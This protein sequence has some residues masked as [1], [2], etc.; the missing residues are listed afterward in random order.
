MKYLINHSLI[1]SLVLLSVSCSDPQKKRPE[2]ENGFLD[3]SSWNFEEDGL[4]ELNGEWEFYWD[5]LLESKD[6]ELYDS[7]K[8]EY[9]HVPGGWATKSSGEKL[10][11]EFG[12]ATYR[13]QIKIPDKNTEYNFI[14]MSIFASAKLWVNGSFCFENGRVA[15]NKEQ[16]KPAFTTE[17][18]S[19]I[20]YNNYSDTLEIIIQVA[21]YS[22][23]GPAA[24]IRRKVAFGPDNQISTE[25]INTSSVNS[26]LIGIL[27]M[28]ALYHTFLFLYR[29]NE[30]SY[31]IFALLS[32]VVV[33][34]AIY[35][36]GMFV[37]SFSYEGYLRFGH[38]GPAIFP[39]LLVLFYY[40]IY[41]NE[42]HKKVVYAFLIIA[43][44]FM[45]IILTSSATTM[46][47]IFTIFSINILI[48]LAYLLGYSLLKAVVRK[49]RGS[50]L[51]YLS[52]LIVF[53]SFMH[54]ALLSNGMIT[55][56]GNYVAAYGY[57]AL[58]NYAI[59]SFGPNVLPNI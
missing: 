46:S 19:P 24:G 25:R 11:S 27:L 15:S 40:F 56:F 29:K 28:I 13:L 39:P 31:L 17:Y 38:I 57:V 51:T 9:I 12:Y 1:V 34:W 32:M 7:I 47:K 53:A 49:R 21:D 45:V 54:D 4:V 20:K 30:I 50:V 3:L 43:M 2:I 14:F 55:G 18:Y 42:V 23:G 52:V 33:I 10:Y 22:Y 59:F 16:S 58:I 6:F 26:L 37:D 8:A 48:P 44:I 41:K 36:S 35:R 5:M